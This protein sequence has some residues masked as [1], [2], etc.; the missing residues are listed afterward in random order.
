MTRTAAATQLRWRRVL[1]GWYTAT[2]RTYSVSATI[3]R[4]DLGLWAVEVDGEKLGLAE[5]LPAAK[6][7]AQAHLAER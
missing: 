3:V 7:V 2:T 4:D 1:P 5:T 6:S